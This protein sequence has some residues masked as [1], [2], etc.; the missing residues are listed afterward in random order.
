M[1]A[2]K[3]K[4]IMEVLP[5][6]TAL[7][8]NVYRTAK[9][10][11]GNPDRCNCPEA[12]RM[13]ERELAKKH[14][15]LERKR[16]GNWVSPKIRGSNHTLPGGGPWRILADCP[17]M[18]HNTGRAAT[19]GAPQH[20]CVCPRALKMA[21]RQRDQKNVSRARIKQL[22]P[23]PAQF[24]TESAYLRNV[25]RPANAPSLDGACHSEHGREIADRLLS[26]RSGAVSEHKRMCGGCPELMRCRTWALNEELPAGAWPGM[27]GGMTTSERIRRARNVVT[28]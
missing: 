12:V 9:L 28:A 15:R 18:L 25:R 19:Q 14:Q 16:E 10:G 1:A 7:E 3:E 4:G 26:G 2:E 22:A 11:R 24:S 6:C 21:E 23:P 17:A 8:H 27:Y 20:R 5:S 13:R